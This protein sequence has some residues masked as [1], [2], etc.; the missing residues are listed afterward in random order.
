MAHKA[1]AAGVWT[2]ARAAYLARVPE[3]AWLLQQWQQVHEPLRN[4]QRDAP[5]PERD[6]LPP[7]AGSLTLTLAEPGTRVDHHVRR[8]ARAYTALALAL[9]QGHTALL[10]AARSAAWRTQLWS[11]HWPALVRARGLARALDMGA[12][13]D[14]ALCFG[15]AG[16]PEALRLWFWAERTGVFPLGLVA[17]WVWPGAVLCQRLCAHG[18]LHLDAYGSWLPKALKQA[19]APCGWQVVSGSCH[20]AWQ[21]GRAV[22]G[23]ALLT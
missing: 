6:L 20:S 17:V 11:R 3:A 5:P 14:G 1:S 23:R 18:N 10:P 7:F 21:Q 19:S 22:P 9:E 12:H 15:A 8:L 16:T 13:F 2:E 4:A